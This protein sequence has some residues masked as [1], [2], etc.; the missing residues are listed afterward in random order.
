MKF[1]P[2]IYRCEHCKCEFIPERME[3]KYCIDCDPKLNSPNPEDMD[4]DEQV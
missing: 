3:D 1:R 2:I 4:D